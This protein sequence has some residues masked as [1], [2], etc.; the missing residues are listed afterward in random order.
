MMEMDSAP[1][2]AM[3]D[4]PAECPDD[5][6]HRVVDGWAFSEVEKVDQI[7]LDLMKDRREEGISQNAHIG[8]DTTDPVEPAEP[9][10][11]RYREYDE[12]GTH[13]VLVGKDRNVLHELLLAPADPA[14]DA[15]GFL[16][17]ASRHLA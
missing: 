2:P 16:F 7:V 1:I 10:H 9:H 11:S 14:P 6:H 3:R 12:H 15:A 8:G 17:F 4:V 13:R 5:K